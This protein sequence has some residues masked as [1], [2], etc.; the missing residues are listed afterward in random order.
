VDRITAIWTD[1][2]RRFGAK[3]PF[4]FGTF[5]IAD[6]MYAP[7][8]SRFRT[9]GVKL[10]GVPAEYA[11]MLWKTPIMQAWMEGAK[12]ES[13]RMARYDAKPAARAS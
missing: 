11:E 8:V 4:L 6:A 5:T 12:G 7:V 1:C 10:T 13:F 3:G 9:Y 2:R